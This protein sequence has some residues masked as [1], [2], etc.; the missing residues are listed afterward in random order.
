MGGE[1]FSYYLQETPGAFFFLGVGN[2]KKAVVYPQHHPK[3]DID[4]AALVSGVE[5]MT[6]AAVRLLAQS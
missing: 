2:E 1:D 5:I 6:R 3:F 4:E